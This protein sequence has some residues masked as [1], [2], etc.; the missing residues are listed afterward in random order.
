MD[1]YTSIKVQASKDN[2]C[3]HPNPEIPSATTTFV[4][5]AIFAIKGI[6]S[7]DIIKRM[8]DFYQ[9]K[10]FTDS[11]SEEDLKV[12]KLFLDTLADLREEDVDD[13]RNYFTEIKNVINKRKI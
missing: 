4:L 11:C 1:L 8:E 7:N 5:L 9:S 2:I 10:N 3:T 12:Q 6:S 13:A